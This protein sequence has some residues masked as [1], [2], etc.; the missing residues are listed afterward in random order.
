[1]LRT[2][3]MTAFFFLL[4]FLVIDFYFYQAVIGVT[5]RLSSSIAR[6]IR[7]LFWLPTILS[8]LAMLWW[9]FDD[10]FKYSANFR[11]WVIT[12]L[13][14]TYLSKIT[15][16]L[17]LFAGDIFRMIH[18]ISDRVFQKP[19]DS[20]QGLM[21]RSEFISKAAVAVASLPLGGFAFG[22]I[23]GP[24]ITDFIKYGSG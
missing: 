23:S 9:I 21:N 6:W 1:M 20:A 15:G 22:I 10:P 8:I 2:R 12:G 19:A 13:L 11:N 17:V 3:I 4:I 14:A 16:V 18:W 5:D 7:I 24:M